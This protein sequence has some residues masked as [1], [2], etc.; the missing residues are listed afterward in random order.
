MRSKLKMNK[1]Q[2]RKLVFICTALLLCIVPGKLSAQIVTNGG[3]ESTSTGAVS[4]TDIDGW[5]IQVDAA[6]TPAPVFEIVDDTVKSGNRALKV[7]VDG[8][9][10][11]P[12]DIQ[13]VADSLPVVPGQKYIYT[14][15][16]K[17]D[18]SGAQVNL[19][20]GN[21]S[22]AEYAAIRPANLTTEWQPFTTEFT[23]NDNET[24]IRAPIHLNY[25]GNA[26]NA[27]YFDN[28]SIV[29]ESFGKTPVTFEAESGTA[30]SKFAVLTDGDVT[31]ISTTENFA[32]SSFPA[33][34]ARMVSYMVNFQD[35]G[36]YNLFARMRVGAGSFNDDSFFAASGFGEKDD[37]TATDWVMVNGLAGAGYTAAVDVVDQVGTAGSSVWKWVNITSGFFPEGSKAT[38]FFVHPDSLTKVFQI[39]TREDGLQFDKF[40][41]GKAHLYYTVEA[42]DSG[43]AGVISVVPFDSSNFYE[44]PPYAQGLSK[45]LGNAL[46]DYPDY[47]FQNYWNQLTP[48]NAGKWGSVASNPDSNLW[49]WIGLDRAYNIAKSNDLIFKNHTL[50]WGQQ[51]PSWISALDPADQLKYI[52]T[53]FN[54]VGTRYPD[55]EMIDVVNEAIATHNPPDGQNGRAN[56]KEALGGNGTTGWDWVIKSFELARKYMPED[57][58]LLLNDY[59]IINSNDATNTYLTIINLLKERNLIDGIGV[60]GHRFE[61]ENAAVSTLKFNLDKLAATGIPV[62]I[63]ELDLGNLNNSGTPDDAIQLE[64]Y[65]KIFPV[66]WTH[67][68]VKG[69]TLWGYLEGQMWQETCFLVRADGTNRPALDWLINYVDTATFPVITDLKE[70]I[71]EMNSKVTVEQNYPNPFNSVTNIQFNLSEP[72]NVNLKIY[73]MLGKELTTLVNENLNSGSYSISW[74]ATNSKGNPVSIGTYY[75]RLVAGE[76]SYTGKMVYIK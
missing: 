46:G 20:I 49:N 4:G 38:S 18:A 52:E 70:N 30:G 11:N 36:N 16:A 50:I 40:A 54:K 32:G 17:A 76:F 6:A 53:W 34:T 13:A 31:H 12:W 8:I 65:K 56:Y 9:G 74:D 59:G 63:S 15:W 29:H 27:V 3:F 25:A 47:V 44:G 22:Y 10:S 57:T 14:I 28:L 69:I 41:F 67:P 43:D 35:S 23:V 62:Y 58:K 7:T 1:N 61:L 60:Q 66:L 26:S 64:L 24:F 33:D 37:S 19:T 48:G 68:G 42:L 72:V 75:Y 21:Y 45:F 2:L 73:D 71:A 51:Q 39:G 55:M 5:V